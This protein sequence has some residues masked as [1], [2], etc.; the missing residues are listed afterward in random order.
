MRIQ[1]HVMS[2]KW[3]NSQISVIIITV[4]T[5]CSII[6]NEIELYTEVVIINPYINVLHYHILLYIKWAEKTRQTALDL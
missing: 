6:D 1:G 5:W 2:T 3:L 4:A